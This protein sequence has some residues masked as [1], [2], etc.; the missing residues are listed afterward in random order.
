MERWTGGVLIYSIVEKTGG[1]ITLREAYWVGF[2]FGPSS[3]LTY[4]MLL[5]MNI[6]S[7]NKK[8]ISKHEC[9]P[10]VPVNCRAASAAS[11]TTSQLLR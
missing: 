8:I 3:I 5:I 4:A 2:E 1:K 6:E 10:A 9:I 7:G 11:K